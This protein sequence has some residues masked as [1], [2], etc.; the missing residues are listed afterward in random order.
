MSSYEF[1]KSQGI[2]CLFLINV[3]VDDQRSKLKAEMA[4]IPPKMRSQISVTYNGKENFLLSLPLEQQKLKVYARQLKVEYN[5][6]NA[7]EVL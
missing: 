7:T 5:I 4:F 2:N 6:L 3:S 1:V